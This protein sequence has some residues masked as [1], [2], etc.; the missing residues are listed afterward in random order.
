MR[1]FTKEARGSISLFLSMIILLLVILEGFLID[2][3]KILA[4]RMYLSSA[5]EMSLNAG[6][7]EYDEALR[8]IYGL[9]ATCKSEEELTANLKVY[10]QK[11]LGEATG[12]GEEETAGYVDQMMS[13]VDTAIRNGWDGEEAG[14]LLDLKLDTGAF[15][16]KGVAGSA[17]SEPYV[18]KNQILEYMKYRGP[19]SLGYGMIEK[20]FA[21]KDLNKQQK[22][23][24]A[25]LDYEESMSDVQRAC[26]EAYANIEAYNQLLEGNLKPE[27]V[28]QLSYDIN[29]AMF[30]AV[31]ATWCY[32]AVKRDPGMDRDWQK[33][34]GQT[35]RDSEGVP[36]VRK[37]KEACR[38]MESMSALY[39]EA[40]Q[41]LSEDFNGHPEAAMQAI[42]I[43]I[44]Y[45][46]EYG[47][48]C[49]LFTTWKR[50]MEY[51]TRRMAE[52]EDML[53]DAEDEEDGDSSEI[54]EEIEEL[55]EQREEY[56]ELYLDSERAINQ[57]RDVLNPARAVLEADIDKRM[58]EATNKL[59]QAARDAKALCQLG[60][61]GREALDGVLRA[62]DQLAS[63]GQ[64]WQ[65]SINNL[66]AGEIKTSMQADYSN[67]SEMLD[68]EKIII[69]QEKLANG[70]SYGEM[71]ENAAKAAM[72]VNYQLFQ[73]DG[74]GSYYPYMKS[75]F[76][77]GAYQGETLPYNGTP[78][79]AFSAAV[80]AGNA[81]HTDALSDPACTVYFN[82]PG[83]GR[84][85]GRI[86]RM[87][88]SV[89]TAQMDSISGKQ[90]DFFLYL[91]RVCPK[92][93]AEKDSAQEA[94]EEKKKLFEKAKDA[95]L[96]PDT[97][98]PTLPSSGGGTG[99]PGYQETD[100]GADDK[101]VSKNAKNNTKGSANFMA[102]VGALLA[103]G[104]DKLYLSEY[105]TQMFS[106]YTV[107]KPG[108]GGEPAVKK[109]LSG[110]PL[111]ADNNAMYKAEVE[112]ILWGNPS[113]TED[114]KYTLTTIF[115]IRFLLN[116]LYA[117]TG[118]PEIRQFTLALATSIAGWTGFGVPLVQSVLIIGFA[119]AETSLDMKAL[120]D[121]KSVP[122][123]K[124]TSTWQIKPTAM[125]KQMIGQAINDAGS[126][127]KNF[128]YD[129]LDELTDATKEAFRNRL[130]EFASETA[131]NLASVAAAA[132]L[133][134][135]QER[136]I[137]MVNVV[138][139]DRDKISGDIRRAIQELKG[140][141]ASEPDSIAKEMKLAA[142]DYFE[143]RLT[144]RIVSAIQGVQNTELS[145]DEITKQIVTELEACRNALRTALLGKAKQLV[146]AE[147]QAVNQALDSGNEAIQEKTSE[148]FDRM[149]MRI[150][151]G[152]SFADTSSV[153]V[154]GGK[155]RTSGAAALT[156]NYK[157]YLWLFIA[158]K[159][160]QSEEDML[161]RIG[162]LIEANLASS[163]TAPSGNFRIQNAFTFIELDAKAD[164]STTFFAMPVPVSGGG[165]VTLGQ[166]QYAIGYRGVLGY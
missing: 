154:D 78:Y 133:T 27:T 50:Y 157:E 34:S 70:I 18:I 47:N 35:I 49:S 146:E 145:N 109:M 97:A 23:M 143:S 140:S 144:G 65:S 152:V 112:Y 95:S 142:A 161:R 52:L 45:K 166:D 59:N 120:V 138:T 108:D 129:K 30:E 147:C 89:Y 14:K 17:L 57:F 125:G 158:V 131:E 44:G 61:A 149:L 126:A 69:L 132:V 58:Q 156:M 53:D 25:K 102:D 22:T 3:S 136:L 88:L 62:M 87:D 9:F 79:S 123:Y 28:E 148:A 76:E 84:M 160:I 42:R 104:R 32:S 21:F 77:S 153:Q 100:S 162:T 93:E 101:E 115:G 19:A 41:G 60:K 91:E 103:K 121:G 66:S 105:A 135:V 134:P 110:Y 39:T 141:I 12:A 74:K 24:E 114:V 56:E 119:L 92:S 7:T 10:F 163:N 46:E 16:A 82:S 86:T 111:T 67:K 106:Y 72:A 37:A 63:K 81:N 124:S 94:K 127:A 33:M 38:L 54:E 83:G 75:R 55:I 80:W 96:N 68:R 36:D 43:I 73:A 1:K 5:G 8:D 155:G 159:S 117:F 137:G 150:D 64:T 48:Y 151:C 107:D 4:A 29:L 118:D 98:L 85:D 139:A 40:A 164:L 15:H 26:E 11:T 6:L 51:Y 90:D 165:S 2:G 122:I 113:G 99:A 31:I 71:L 130:S 13:Y 128:L 116:S 20:I